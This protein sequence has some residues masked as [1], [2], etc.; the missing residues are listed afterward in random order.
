MVLLEL[1]C[2]CLFLVASIFFLNLLLLPAGEDPWVSNVIRAS[3]LGLWM[4][5][6][7]VVLWKFATKYLLIARELP[8]MY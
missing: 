5:A 8:I 3:V 1:F 2:L 7:A 4:F 6:N